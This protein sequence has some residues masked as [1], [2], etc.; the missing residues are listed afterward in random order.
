MPQQRAV[1]RIVVDEHQT[2][3]RELEH[4]SRR[5]ATQRVRR[6]FDSD[7]EIPDIRA[8]GTGVQEVF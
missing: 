6:T 3:G 4:G 8:G 5:T 2:H 1:A 7:Q